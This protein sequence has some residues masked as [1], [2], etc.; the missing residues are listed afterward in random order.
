MSLENSGQRALCHSSPIL[1]ILTK[2]Q[3]GPLNGIVLAKVNGLKGIQIVRRILLG[4]DTAAHRQHRPCTRRVNAIEAKPKSDNYFVGSIF[5][6]QTCP[7][8]RCTRRIHVQFTFDTTLR[9]RYKS[10]SWLPV[11]MSQLTD[12]RTTLTPLKYLRLPHTIQRQPT[13]KQ[14]CLEHMDLSS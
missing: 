1:L 5:F 2:K 6:C 12:S 14:S 4:Y 3:Y 9:T 13:A 11:I 7:Q 8:Q 10:S